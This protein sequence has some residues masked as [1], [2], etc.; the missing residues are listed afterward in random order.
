MVTRMDVTNIKIFRVDGE[1]LKAYVSVVFDDSFIVRD[2]KVI[3]GNNG[4]FVA[5]PSKR[6]KD[7]TYKDIAHPVNQKMRDFLEQRI[8][9]KYMN[10]SFSHA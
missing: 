2:I 9:Q 4:L 6:S 1:K 5:M 7:G 3:S 10:G 8:L